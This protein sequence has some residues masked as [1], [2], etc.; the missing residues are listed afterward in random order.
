MFDAEIAAPALA[1]VDPSVKIATE[2]RDA[3]RPEANCQTCPSRSIGLCSDL[4]VQELEHFRRASSRLS[5]S[6]EHELIRQGEPLRHVQMVVT[7]GLM[8]SRVA[9]DGR[10]FVTNFAW[11][12]DFVG[13][14]TE[15]RSAF[16]AFALGPT[17]ICRN[18]HA[19]FN[20][21]V[22]ISP[23]LA[24]RLFIRM[25]A[26]LSVAQDHMVSLGCGSARERVALFLVRL[27]ERQGR[28]EKR[29]ARIDLPMRR[30]DVAAHLGLTVETVSRVFQDLVRKKIIMVIPDGVRILAHEALVSIVDAIPENARIFLDSPTCEPSARIRFPS[31]TNH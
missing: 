31:A 18:S 3:K 5:L 7:G 21:L 16:S 29:L 2:P 11:P 20:A 17:E 8:L 25:H 15:E 9:E 30:F 6:P 14:V 24:Q 1:G 28:P 13:L 12:G 23:P 22:A 26:E 10:R 4:D 19:E 27:H